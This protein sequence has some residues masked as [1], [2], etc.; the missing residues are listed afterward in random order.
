VINASNSMMHFANVVVSSLVEALSLIW[1]EFVMFMCAVLG[2]AIFLGPRRSQSK[3]AKAADSMSPAQCEEERVGRELQVQMERGNHR[4]AFKLWQCI[5]SLESSAPSGTLPGVVNSMRKL[6]KSSAEILA[7]LRSAFECNAALADGL[8]E[9]IDALKKGDGSAESEA[10]SSGVSQLFEDFHRSSAKR[11]EVAD[12]RIKALTVLLRQSKL[13][14]VLAQIE[15]SE[16]REVMAI[17]PQHVVTR[18]LTLVLRDRR[19]SELVP[20]LMELGM[21]FSTEV[22]DELL[23]ETGRRKDTAMFRQLYFLAGAAG[24]PKGVQALEAFIRGL[25][26]DTATMTA[27]FDEVIRQETI[28]DS[29]WLA[30]LTA[31]TTGQHTKLV[32]GLLHRLHPDSGATL[33]ATQTILASLIRACVACKLFTEACNV[34]EAEVQP[35]EITL[36]SQVI[37]I[38]MKAATQAGRTSLAQSLLEQ[39]PADLQQHVM[40]IKTCGRKQDLRGAKDA[41]DQLS[42]SGTPMTP[43]VYNCLLDACIQC[44]DMAGAEAHFAQMKQLDY[45]DVVSYNTML[46]SHLHAG[47]SDAAHQILHE[48]SERGLPANKVTYN[49]LLNARVIAKDRR[50][51]WQLIGDMKKAGLQPN[52]VTISILLKSLTQHSHTQDVI[53]T[54]ELLSQMEEPMD[55]V[56][57]SSVIEACIRTQRLDLLSDIMRKY[58]QQ[59]GLLKLTA[60][61]YGSMIKAYGQ[62]HDVERLWELWNEMSHREV[63]PTAIT[64]GC[65]IDALV[66]NGCVED[67]WEL[68]NTMLSN[69]DTSILVNTVIYSTVL[70][71]FAMSKQ[72]SRIFMVYE[73]MTKRGVQCNTI[74]YNTML[75]A[76][77]RCG[78]MEQVPQLLEDMKAGGVDPDVITYSTIVKGYCLSGDVDRAFQVLKEM[79]RDGRFAPDEILYNSLL[80][81]CAKEHR[82]DEAL[83]LL[84][85]MRKNGITP[86]N[87]TLSILVKLMGRSRRLNQ[88]FSIIDELCSTH[89]FHPNIQVYT[90]LIQAC[91]QNRQMDRALALH[92]KMISESGCQPDQKLYSVLVRGCLQSGLAE[93]AAEVVRCAY[94]V[95]GHTMAVAKRFSAPGIEPRTLEDVVVR[96]NTGSHAERDCAQRLVS[97]LKGCR[98]ATAVQDTVYAQVV[99]QATRGPARPKW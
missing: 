77:A 58:A 53:S 84:E 59:G 89:G 43:M 30:L 76:C 13:D 94:H 20:K 44:G 35:Q 87:Y 86:S 21:Q 51:I 3:N 82:V 52:T 85:D 11:T 9:L 68:L 61:T 69:E 1:V 25:A 7:E 56:L 88:A 18:L 42:Q 62:A 34:F 19:V 97:D 83:E 73:E 26:A 99:R 92:D 47:R 71:G 33:P 75:H 23:R 91:I 14:E 64:L 48:M 10:L 12:P 4:A 67:A 98:G 2:Y 28:P 49:E 78:S 22:L 74:S 55:E 81:G 90:C 16:D 24:I 63:K 40:I 31:S 41:F 79:K 46:K 66:K 93:K 29:L 45:A 6:G 70:K 32:R 60:P 72:S 8:P 80:D 96:L 38:L 15:E 17:L 57:F 37:S 5:K 27:L 36:D 95:P 50:G 65:M 39:C 54:M